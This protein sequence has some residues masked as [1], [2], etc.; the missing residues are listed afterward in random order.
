MSLAGNWSTYIETRRNPG[1]KQQR[2]REEG[3]GRRGGGVRGAVGGRG[4]GRPYG[5]EGGG[6]ARGSRAAYVER[7]QAVLLRGGSGR[8]R[9]GEGGR[10]DQNGFI[11]LSPS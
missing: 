6:I 8:R 7:S 9:G 3:W 11:L 1:R 10:H 2:P 5:P 4:E